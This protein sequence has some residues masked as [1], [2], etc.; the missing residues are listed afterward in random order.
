MNPPRGRLLRSRVV[1]DLRTVLVAAL[2]RDLSGYAVLEPQ[3]VLL[4]D[5]DGEG[6]L[7]FENG[8]PVLA[9]HSGTG[10][11]GR[12]ALADLVVDGPC[13]LELYA[14]DDEGLADL[15][16]TPELRVP[17][18]LPAERLAGDPDLASRLRERAPAD[19]V[20]RDD[21]DESGTDP[22]E[23]FLEDDRKIEAIQERAREE[24]RRRAEEWGFGAAT[25]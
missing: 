16:D 12:E 15:H 18:G 22:V 10:R 24:A 5:A 21:G 2:E 23:A 7:T 8:V 11:G 4:L 19:R 14:L 25:E 13:W 17:P 3:D 1:S 6:I 9:Y 20:Q